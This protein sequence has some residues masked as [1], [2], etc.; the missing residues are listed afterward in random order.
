MPYE[1][2]RVTDHAVLRWLERECGVD[3]EA[4]RRHIAGLAIDG[5]RLG[6]VG[7]LVGRVRIAIEQT[8]E[9]PAVTT[10]LKR[11]QTGTRM[12]QRKRRERGWWE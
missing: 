4:V 3:V 10:V 9:P 2:L 1:D 5:A 6:A 12:M 8:Q 7:V 11:S